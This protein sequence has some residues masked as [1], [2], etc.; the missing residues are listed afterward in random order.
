MRPT[1]S[2]GFSVLGLTIGRAAG[3]GLGFGFGEAPPAR[4]LTPATPA[5]RRISRLFFMAR[6]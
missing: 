6:D 2:P 3:A 5:A 4:A 1:V